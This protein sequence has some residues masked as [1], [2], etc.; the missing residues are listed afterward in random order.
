MEPKWN[1]GKNKNHLRE[2]N[3]DLSEVKFDLK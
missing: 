2:Q 1:K 3:E